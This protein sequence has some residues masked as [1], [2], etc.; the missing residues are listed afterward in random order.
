MIRVMKIA[1]NNEVIIPIPSVVANPL[2][3]PVPKKNRIPAVNNV[4]T[5]ASIIAD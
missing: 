4:V 3:G 1:E 5:L 2:I